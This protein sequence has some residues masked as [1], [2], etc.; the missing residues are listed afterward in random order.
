MVCQK[1][2]GKAASAKLQTVTHAYYVGML[3]PSRA[4]RFV[5]A[6]PS[7]SAPSG[8]P[9]AAGGGPLVTPDGSSGPR[10]IALKLYQRAF[11]QKT[12]FFHSSR[13]W[14]PTVR[15]RPVGH[16]QPEK[17]VTTLPDAA[18]EL[19]GL[20]EHMDKGAYKRPNRGSNALLDFLT[21]AARRCCIR[22]R[23]R[24][25]KPS[26]RGRRSRVVLSEPE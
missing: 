18:A 24:G 23:R 26:S 8:S 13:P 10:E 20:S 2:D 4:R 14:R 6:P 7:A 19:H 1:A 25:V 15:Y 21:R 5:S 12:P 22:H 9:R 17:C 3:T 11:L 16:S